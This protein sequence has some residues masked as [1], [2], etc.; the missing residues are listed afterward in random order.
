MK[1]LVVISMVAMAMS[2]GAASPAMAIT[3]MQCISACA[4]GYNI[5]RADG[6]APIFCSNQQ[7]AC[8]G[9]CHNGEQ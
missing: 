9:N 2:A 5:C 1:K 3:F 8:E 4:Q 6:G 7:M